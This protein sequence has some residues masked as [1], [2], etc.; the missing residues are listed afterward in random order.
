MYS[1][2]TLLYVEIY[3]LSSQYVS[4]GL[5]APLLDIVYW[6]TIVSPVK[7]SSFEPTYDTTRSGGGARMTSTSA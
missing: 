3:Q 7:Y 1:R 4:K 2:S 5:P 6:T